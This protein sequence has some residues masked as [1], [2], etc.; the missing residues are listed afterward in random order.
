MCWI[1]GDTVDR[2]LFMSLQSGE[3]CRTR[4][5]RPTTFLRNISEVCFRVKP[6]C[7]LAS[8]KTA[9]RRV[10]LESVGR[11]ILEAGRPPSVGLG[12]TAFDP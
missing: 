8:R 9:Q 6:S 5:S 11:E 3:K 12:P 2:Y 4:I 1:D 10:P 7:S